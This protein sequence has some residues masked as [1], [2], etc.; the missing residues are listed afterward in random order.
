[1]AHPDHDPDVGDVIVVPWTAALALKVAGV[2]GDER[3]EALA[4]V[5][6]AIDDDRLPLEAVDVLIAAGWDL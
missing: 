5:R 6:D 3:P 2:N 1:V 4:K